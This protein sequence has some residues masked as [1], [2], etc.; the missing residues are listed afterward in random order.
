MLNLVLNFPISAL[1]SLVQLCY[2]IKE[3]VMFFKTAAVMSAG[4]HRLTKTRADTQQSVLL[5]WIK[6]AEIW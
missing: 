3:W 2:A 1:G 5:D 6:T 4:G